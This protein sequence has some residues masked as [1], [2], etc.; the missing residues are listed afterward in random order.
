MDLAEAISEERFEPACLE[1]ASVEELVAPRHVDH[2]AVSLRT[3]QLPCCE[4]AAPDRHIP[5]PR[6]CDEKLEREI[7][8]FSPKVFRF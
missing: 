8:P 3:P 1:R 7:E 5:P 2:G 6:A 4:H